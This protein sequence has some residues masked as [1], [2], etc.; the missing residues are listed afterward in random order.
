MDVEHERSLVAWANTFES[1]DETA[2]AARSFAD[3]TSG[4]LLV[5]IARAIVGYND[6]SDSDKCADKRNINSVSG[7]AG[8]FSHMKTVGL[9]EQDAEIPG[10]EADEEKLTLA[11]TCLEALLRHTVGEQ[12][13]DRETFIRQI[14]SLDASAQTTLRYIIVGHSNDGGN[15]EA[16]SPSRESAFEGSVL[17]SPMPSTYSLDSPSFDRSVVGCGDGGDLSTFKNLLSPQEGEDAREARSAGSL[18]GEDHAAPV[19]P[20]RRQARLNLDMETGKDAASVAASAGSLPVVVG[21]GPTFLT[22]AEVR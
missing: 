19:G 6:D 8:V 4:E 3:F 22:A 13:V 2:C 10:A 14:M 9:L 16:C 21:G 7:W 18:G 20:K 1:S 17:G 11:V 5:Q 15:S 12:C